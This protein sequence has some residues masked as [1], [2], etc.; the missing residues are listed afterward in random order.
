MADNEIGPRRKHEAEDVFVVEEEGGR[1]E[2]KE[3]ST[4][5]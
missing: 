5:D 1:D 2:V 3:A 4:I